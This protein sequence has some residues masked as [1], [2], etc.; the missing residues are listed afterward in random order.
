MPTK[1]KYI[2]RY[3][4]DKWADQIPTRPYVVFEDGEFWSYYELWERTRRLASSLQGLGVK[5]GDHVVVWLPHGIEAMLLFF[6]VNYIGAVYVP[7]N[8][9]YK[10]GVL[11]HVLEVAD[12]KYLVAHSELIPRLNDIKTRDFKTIVSVGKAATWIGTAD[13]VDYQTATEGPGDVLP[14]KRPIEGWDKQAIIFTSGTTGVS[15]GVSISYLQTLSSNEPFHAYITSSDR[16]LA[17]LPMFHVGG[18]GIC[19]TMLYIG[20]S[21]AINKG[22]NTKTFWNTV[23]AT[24]STVVFMMGAMAQFVYKLP[25]TAQ[26]ADN[27]LHTM[28]VVPMIDN[29]GAFS[30]RFRLNIYT[31]YHQTEISTPILSGANPTKNLTCGRL[32]AGV[33]ARLVDENDVEVAAGG[34]GELILRT[35]R[36]WAMTTGYAKNPE[37]TVKLWRNGWLHTGD[38]FRRDE[39]GD[40]FFVDR[41][42]DAIRRRGENI[43]SMEVEKEVI[44]HKDILEVAAV[45]V[46]SEYSEDE[47]MVVV[48]PVPGRTIDP[49]QLTE[50][51]RSRLAHFMVPRYIRVLPE[52]PK[53]PTAKVQKNVLRDLGVTEDTWDREAEGIVIK[54]DRLG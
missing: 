1:D 27:S 43:S 47:V 35:D 39:D 45:A 16:Y 25:P 4:L 29:V 20:G 7:I 44:A 23:H 52:L 14:L 33:E 13:M 22:F 53:T 38:S 32:R 12:A 42:K 10:G 30:T 50:F 6:A 26:D 9:A 19:S 8:P 51:L 34:I 40:F 17:T 2:I 36:P 15:K 46:P 28:I 21:I 48:A 18:I 5:Q 37:A 24:Q 54:Q 11:Q 31:M 3:L 41:L 49:V